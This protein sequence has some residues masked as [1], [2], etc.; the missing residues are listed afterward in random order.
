MDVD[1][2]LPIWRAFAVRGLGVSASQGG[3]NST[4]DGVAAFDLPPGCQTTGVEDASSGPRANAD[5]ALQAH[6]NP[7][8]PQTSL[9]FT[10]QS[11]GMTALE[12]YDLQ[13]RLVRHI[14]G[15]FLPAGRHEISWD[16]RGDANRALASGEYIVPHGLLGELTTTSFVFAVTAAA[17]ASAVTLNPLLSGASTITGTPSAS[18]TCSG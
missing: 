6:P 16:G 13:G 14:D 10:L 3:V 1:P 12:I 8:N 11:R 5:H 15:G 9:F 18:F 17:M 4:L 7:F 2:E